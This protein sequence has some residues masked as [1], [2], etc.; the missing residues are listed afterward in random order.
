MPVEG[1]GVGQF[2]KTRQTQEQLIV[3]KGHGKE[4]EDDYPAS[5]TA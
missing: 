1:Q 4:R 3:K 2:K 5:I